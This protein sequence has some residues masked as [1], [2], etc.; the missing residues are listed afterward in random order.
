M[1]KH[2]RG[3]RSERS[4]N[5]GQQITLPK[6]ESIWIS[7]G[8]KHAAIEYAEA[9]GTLLKNQNFTTS[10]IRNFFGELKRIQLKGIAG[11]QASFHLLRPK[12]AYAAARAKKTGGRES[13]GAETFKNAILEA[14]REVDIDNE[15][16]EK[17]FA[18]FCDLIEAIL[19][20]HKA[21]GG[22]D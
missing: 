1:N 14:H 13:I 10:Q 4:S 6:F 21:A 3:G 15:G 11:E 17:R 9:L 20:F 18:N 8:I 22:K 19:A 16:Y 12:L 7:E 5:P 2:D